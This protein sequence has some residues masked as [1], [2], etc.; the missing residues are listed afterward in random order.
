MGQPST[1]G[2]GAA[3]GDPAVVALELSDVQVVRVVPAVGQ[4]GGEILRTVDAQAIQ[5]PHEF[6]EQRVAAGEDELEVQEAGEERQ[7]HDGAQLQ[8]QDAV[9]RPEEIDGKD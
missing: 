4:L 3:N 2:I 7:Q 1:V 9:G 6:L 8:Q 5:I